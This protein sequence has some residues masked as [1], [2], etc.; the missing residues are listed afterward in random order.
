MQQ[1]VVH[2]A[3]VPAGAFGPSSAPSLQIPV[4]HARFPEHVVPA[5]CVPGGTHSCV[6]GSQTLGAAQHPGVLGDAAQVTH[7]AVFEMHSPV[8]GTHVSPG[9]QTA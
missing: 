8:C 6:P 5:S 7:A 4:V 3:A 9:G 1:G 2:E